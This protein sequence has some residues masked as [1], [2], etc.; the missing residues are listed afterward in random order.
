MYRVITSWHHNNN[1][2]TAL[3]NI[4]DKIT[5]IGIGVLVDNRRDA[6][7]SFHGATYIKLHVELQASDSHQPFRTKGKKRRRETR[8]SDEHR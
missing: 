7:A 8:A 2:L 5:S 6:C 4:S 1:H 3:L